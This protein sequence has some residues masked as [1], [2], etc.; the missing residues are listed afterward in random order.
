[1]QGV[2][3]KTKKEDGMMRLTDEGRKAMEEGGGKL[4]DGK[5]K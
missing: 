2:G 1:M 5:S 4:D 3:R